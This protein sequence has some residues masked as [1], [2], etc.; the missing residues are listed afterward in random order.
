MNILQIILFCAKEGKKLITIKEVKGWLEIK[1]F[2]DLP[3]NMYKNHEC[4]TPPLY[5][6]E[7]TIFTKKNVYYDTC[8]SVFFNAYDG[9]KHVGRI[10]GIIQHASNEKT[11]EKRARFTRFDC[12][13]DQ[14]VATALFHAVEEWAKD[15]GCDII[16]GPLGFSDLE[17]EGLLIEGFEW[18]N[19]FEEQYNF[20]YYAGLIENLGYEKET[21]WV[22]YRLFKPEPN[23]KIERIKN[24]VLEKYQLRL[25]KATNVRE[26]IKTYKDGIF[27]VLDEG[28]KELYGTVPF[29]DRMK[30]QLI[31]Q[32]DLIVKE[33]CVGVILDKDDN[34]VAFGLCFP[35]IG[36][37]LR[38]GNGKLYPRT[39]FKL[40]KVLKNPKHLDLALIAVLP[41]Y[42]NL[43]VNSIVLDG[44]INLMIEKDIEY[45]ETNLNL[46]DNYPIQS[47]WKF[48]P[49]VQ[50]K[51]RRSYFK[52]L[53]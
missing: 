45:C 53:R 49:H 26:F 46:E 33:D 30:K 38:G 51:R 19:T 2:L 4:Y 7:K 15:K 52:K 24:L 21:D 35:S 18:H 39:L 31:S 16:C 10:Q 27:Y 17:R 44:L 42:R 22:E 41:K 20:P 8:E 1:R 25:V 36:D 32:F 9:K 50:H 23:K 43:G 37:A 3:N 12:I 29:S 14:N 11:G 48:F 13:E 34:V 28:Y 40:L 6:D 47:Q 5:N